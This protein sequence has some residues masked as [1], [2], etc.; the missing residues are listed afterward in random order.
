M[1]LPT[2]DVQYLPR[3]HGV[4]KPTAFTIY[5]EVGDISRFA[6][7]KH[8]SSFGRLVSGSAKYGG[9]QRHKR[10]KDGNPYLMAFSDAGI[11]AVQYYPVVRAVYQD[12][13]AQKPMPTA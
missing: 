4:G 2:T 10:S 12:L 13:L 9:Y 1:L 5:L 3:I 7:E 8:F 11:R 6:F